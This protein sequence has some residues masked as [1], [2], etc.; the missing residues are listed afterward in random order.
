MLK[1]EPYN[2]HAEVYSGPFIVEKVEKCNVEISHK[3][4][5]KKKYVHKN[6]IVKK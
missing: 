4:G 6:R 5:G 1:N 2:K 3:E